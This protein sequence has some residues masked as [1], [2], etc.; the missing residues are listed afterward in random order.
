MKNKLC[1]RLNV[2]WLGPDTSE[3]M[4]INVFCIFNDITIL[5][6]LSAWQVDV[7]GIRKMNSVD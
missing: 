6:L 7:V 2:I 5:T 4:M 1:Q 3:P